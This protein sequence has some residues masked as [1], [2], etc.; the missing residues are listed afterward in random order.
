MANGDVTKVAILGRYLLP[1]G[2]NTTA[3]AQ[4][5][6]KVFL[7]GEITCT[8][9]STGIDIG[10][11]NAGAAMNSAATWPD[12][13]GLDAVDALE[14]TLKSTGGA[15][16]ADDALYLFDVSHDTWL[17]HGLEDVGVADAAAPS[18]G[19]ALVL[20]FWAVGDKGT[21]GELT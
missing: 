17:I 15:A 16:V 9:L 8:G 13:L 19:D 3:G 20:S 21:E 10:T 1:G 6:N 14:F 2:G 12:A 5:Q 18:D 11:G 4:R 7:W